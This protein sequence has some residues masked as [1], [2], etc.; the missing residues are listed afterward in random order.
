M[1]LLRVFPFPVFQPSSLAL[2]SP[3]SPAMQND[4]GEMVDMYIPR[5]CSATNRMIGAGDYASVQLN[6]GHVSEDGCVRFPAPPLL[7]GCFFRPA[8]P[9]GSRRP[10][11]AARLPP[12]AAVAAAAT[13]AA[14]RR[15]CSGDGLLCK[16]V[17]RRVCGSRQ[18]RLRRCPR[19]RSRLVKD[20]PA[21]GLQVAGGRR[22]A[23]AVCGEL[24]RSI[25]A[26]FVFL[27]AGRSNLCARS[28]SLYTKEYTTFAFSGYI[29]KQVRA[30]ALLATGRVR[31]AACARA[32]LT[33]S[34]DVLCSG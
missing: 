13:A 34:A 24:L 27:P 11:P 5:K 33:L 7:G 23:A 28:C 18:R 10:A 30:D 8:P 22:E 3:A 25:A 4:A 12:R 19:G 31:P 26:R 15:R 20:S 9:P 2:S 14:T 29:R 21:A 16:P 1:G 32:L 17:G 6:I